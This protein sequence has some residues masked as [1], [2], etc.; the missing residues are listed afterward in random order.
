MR[1]GK[2]ER[3]HAWLAQRGQ[4]LA[5]FDSTAYSDSINDLP[6]LEAVDTA[7][8]VDP[9]ARLAAIARERGWAVLRIH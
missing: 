7:V 3:L 2:V 6:L 9:D 5:Q 4:A 1:K 8:V